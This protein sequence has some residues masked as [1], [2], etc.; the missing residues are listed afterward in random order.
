MGDRAM[1]EITHMRA[2]IAAMREPVFARYRSAMMGEALRCR[3]RV[4]DVTGMRDMSGAPRVDR[5]SM[6]AA[7]V[8]D[9][10]P[11]TVTEMR[12]AAVS[13]KT[14]KMR[15]ATATKMRGATAKV[16]AASTATEMRGATTTKVGAASTTTKV[17]ATSTAT[18]VGATST[19]TKMRCGNCE[20]ES[21][22]AKAQSGRQSNNNP[23]RH[24]TTPTI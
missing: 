22:N 15:G 19:A 17:G 23:T 20:R 21:G 14:A 18:K 3:T 5:A 10:H 24:S 6:R 4:S 8:T 7:A 11:A 1:R 12:T 2:T 13:G 16:G 9:M